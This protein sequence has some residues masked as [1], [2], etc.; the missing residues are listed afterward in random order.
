MSLWQHVIPRAGWLNHCGGNCRSHQDR[1]FIATRGSVRLDWRKRSPG[2]E[3]VRNLQRWGDESA[4]RKEELETENWKGF[5]K[6]SSPAVCF[7]DSPAGQSWEPQER[8]CR[9]LWQTTRSAVVTF[10]LHPKWSVP[11]L[12]SWLEPVTP[13]SEVNHTHQASD[14]PWPT[15]FRDCLWVVGHL[16]TSSDGKWITVVSLICSNKLSHSVANRSSIASIYIKMIM[17]RTF[18]GVQWLR[19]CLLKQ[20]VWVQSLVGRAKI[21]H[22]LWPK[23]PRT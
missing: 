1:C 14:P 18:L 21:P 8:G 20:R 16:V 13:C 6:S 2:L 12:T 5:R 19:L 7:L 4:L 17:S 23:K 9:E 15:V 22:A 3:W 11:I 10:G